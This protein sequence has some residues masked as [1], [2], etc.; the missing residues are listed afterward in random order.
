MSATPLT[1]AFIGELDGTYMTEGEIAMCD[2]AR[3]LEAKLASL[4]WR[5]VAAGLPTEG[6]EDDVGDVEWSDGVDIW[7]GL[8]SKP[9]TNATHWRPIHLPGQSTSGDITPIYR[10][11][12]CGCITQVEVSCDCQ[13]PSLN[14]FDAGFAVFSAP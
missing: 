12:G 14:R 1:D 13:V 10:C 11:Q 5:P 3:S 7:Q 6:D 8:W 2:F 9:K 4:D